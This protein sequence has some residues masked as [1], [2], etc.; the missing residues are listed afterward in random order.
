MQQPYTHTDTYRS[1]NDR[2]PAP[3]VVV[4][5]ALALATPVAVYLLTHPA[6]ALAVLTTAVTTAAVVDRD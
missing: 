2:R 1:P 5:L 4:S 3:P 6:M